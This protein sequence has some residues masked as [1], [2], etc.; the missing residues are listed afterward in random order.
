MA[1][2]KART[3]KT[4]TK[5]AST[6]KAPARKPRANQALHP[7]RLRG[8]LQLEFKMAAMEV[9]LKRSKLDKTNA[10]LGTLSMDP[11]HAAV[12][13]LMKRKEDIAAEMKDSVVAFATIQK[14]IAE[15]FG[16]PYDKLH[17]YTIDTD[18]GAMIPGS[19]KTT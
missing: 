14:K 2:A 19:A 10:E 12:F 16:I 1:K 11:Q 13:A 17:E 3:V 5:K 4:R 7:Y 8:K 6:T 15:K 18:T 9:E